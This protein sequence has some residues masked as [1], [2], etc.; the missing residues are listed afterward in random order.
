MTIPVERTRV[1][2][3]AVVLAHNRRAAV[4]LVLGQLDKLGV[5]EVIVVD[6]AS[7]DGTTEMIR[8]RYPGVHVVQA[9]NIGAAG[10]N[11][12]VEVAGNEYVLLLDDDAYPREGAVEA[13]LATFAADERTA[14]VAGLVRDTVEPADGELLPA[15]PV[16]VRD[17]ELGTFDW[18]LRAGRAGDVPPEGLPTFFFPEGASMV[19]RSR[20]LGSG[21]FYAPYFLATSEIDLTTRLL[22]HGWDVRY[23]PAAQFDHMKVRAGRVASSAILHYR[24]RNQ[25]WYFRRHFPPALA[26]RRM[27]SYLAFDLVQAVYEHA[28]PHWWRGVYEAWSLREQVRHDVRPLPRAVLRRAEMNRGRLHLQ[29]LARQVHAKL[30]RRARRAGSRRGWTG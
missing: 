2:V 12:G 13:L 3:S 9:E 11:L 10:R 27:V 1:P 4:D 19:R 17:V 24:V 30:S 22:A 28:V 8:T 6:N 7:S 29:L 5:D 23:Q 21:G 20:F 15:D 25:L 16:V 26:F 18:W 14:V